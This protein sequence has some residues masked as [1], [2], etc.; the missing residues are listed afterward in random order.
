MNHYKFNPNPLCE[1]FPCH[2]GVLKEDF[3]CLF[4]YC[5]LYLLG[6]DCGGNYSYR[7]GVKDCSGCVKPHD[8]GSY[9]FVMS[10][11]HLIFRRQ[12]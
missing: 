7:D 6:R 2:K 1:Y 12:D 4:C 3:N 8:R 5:P 10:K 9:D 11:M